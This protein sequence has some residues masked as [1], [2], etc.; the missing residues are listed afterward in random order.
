MTVTPSDYPDLGR[1]GSFDPHQAGYTRESLLERTVWCDGLWVLHDFE[2][3][4]GL[5]IKAVLWLSEVGG[6]IFAS[7]FVL[8]DLNLPEWLQEWYDEHL[9]KMVRLLNVA[10]G[11]ECT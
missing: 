6:Y 11:C 7:G 5:V 1:T 9:A 4:P 10:N 2:P 8:P 3:E